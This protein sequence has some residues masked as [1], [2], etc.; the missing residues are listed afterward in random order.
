MND[1]FNKQKVFFLTDQTKD[2][3]FRINQLDHLYRLIVSNEQNILDALK[4]DL[5]KSSFEAYTT[6]IGFSLHSIQ[7][8][9]KHLKK[10]MK[11]KKVKTP[12]YQLNT[13]SYIYPEPKGTIL[14]IGPYNY[15][16]QLIIEPLI[17]AIASGNTAILK[18]SEF[19][20]E[21]EKVLLEMINQNF[22]ES[23]IRVFT[24][25]KEITS[26]LLTYPFDHIFFTG[27]TKVGQ[28]VY[29]AAAKN[30]TPV[31]LE[32]GGK[33]PTIVDETA[34]IKVATRR[35]AFAKFTNAGQTCIAPDYI[36]CHHKI[37]DQ[38]IKEL[39]D[40]I[41]T[42]YQNYD[43]FGKIINERHFNRLINLINK[44]KQTHENHVNE[45]KL[46]ISPTVLKDVTWDDPVMQEEIFGP[47]LPV[48]SYHDENELIQLLKTK[49]KPLALYL[50]SKKKD[51]QQKIW[52]SISFG[53]GAIN[54]ALMHVSNPYLPFG[55]VGSSGF[56]AYHGK[57]SFDLFS[58]MKG[59]IKRSTWLDLPIAYPPYSKKK[60]KLIRK[61]LK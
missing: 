38:F 10:W 51:L 21:T 5:N 1:I 19:A 50:F 36:Y 60:E 46:H 30:L 54:D 27:S 55:G 42:F 26:E 57:H 12:F 3:N 18:P 35:I 41:I 45:E 9:R 32:L 53:G 7:K 49:E 48:L 22:D 8:A 61:L 20:K 6:E 25:E 59:Y 11:P 33:S 31:T 29:E 40:V 44:Q 39:N 4:K 13:K 17:G 37:H 23:Y 43:D 58:H 34:N 52:N 56:G 15:P 14:I 24:G 28:I 16:F 47:I 2:Y